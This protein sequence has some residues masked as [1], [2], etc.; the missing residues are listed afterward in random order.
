MRYDEEEEEDEEIDLA[1]IFYSAGLPGAQMISTHIWEEP[2]EPKK[3]VA[4]HSAPDA[5]FTYTRE[6][7]VTSH[8]HEPVWF[9]IDRCLHCILSKYLRLRPSRTTSQLR[10][11]QLLSDYDGTC[12]IHL[13]TQVEGD[14]ILDTTSTEVM[15]SFM[16]YIGVRTTDKPEMYF[17]FVYGEEVRYVWNRL[18]TMYDIAPDIITSVNNVCSFPSLL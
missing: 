10:E 8:G 13:S 7:F 3:K 15:S 4:S 12:R 18:I 14:D 2:I 5:R 17:R 1:A 16:E 6:E 11:I 9:T